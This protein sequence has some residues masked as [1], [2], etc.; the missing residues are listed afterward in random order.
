MG[1][2]WQKGAVISAHAAYG[3]I[4]TQMR[5]QTE[6]LNFNSVY[7]NYSWNLHFTFRVIGLNRNKC[8]KITSIP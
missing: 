1:I 3:S 2:H 6:R 5:S 4:L 7:T 8:I